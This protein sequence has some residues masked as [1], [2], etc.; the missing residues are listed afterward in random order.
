MDSNA[1][2][3]TRPW[4][5]DRAL[6]ALLLGADFQCIAYGCLLGMAYTYYKR[7]TQD[8]KWL[9]FAILLAWLLCTLCCV[10]ILHGI[11]WFTI[12]NYGNTSAIQ[13]SPWSVSL[14]T[15]MMSAVMTIVRLVFLTR[16]YKLYRAKPVLSPAIVLL[17]VLVAL[18][19]LADL[20][21]AIAITVTFF[22]SIKLLGLTSIENLFTAMFSVGIAADVIL[23]A[24]LCATL[25]RSRS[26]L[27]RTDS[28]INLLI[29]YTIRTGAIPCGCAIATLIA[30]VCSPESMIY[31][32]FYVQT[33]N[34]YL[35]S[36]LATLNYR[37]TIQ[38]RI[39]QPISLDF[40]AFDRCT[41]LS[42]EAQASYLDGRS[43]DGCSSPTTVHSRVSLP[44]SL[45]ILR[46]HSR[47]HSTASAHEVDLKTDEKDHRE[48]S[49]VILGSVINLRLPDMSA[50]P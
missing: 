39:Q 24:M 22:Q 23:T 35:V 16:V 6:G 15:T 46:I 38:T 17:I 9:R 29:M 26:G 42:G 19:S 18:L 11:Y 37:K 47:K 7:S 43:I 12:T 1:N 14:L 5:Y 10:I 40:G 8:P 27:Q 4:I 44:K 3:Y 33:A 21:G 49:E 34:L 28:V 13:R 50:S 31:A 30:F 41:T 45:R 20:G 2:P 32:P 25:H 48:L 36:L